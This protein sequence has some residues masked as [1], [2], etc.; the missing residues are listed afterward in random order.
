MSRW[1]QIALEAEEKTKPLPDTLQEPAKR[2]EGF[3]GEHLTDTLQKPAETVLPQ[4]VCARPDLLQV[5]AV[6]RADNP[7]ES[8]AAS[9]VPRKA[10]DMGHGLSPGGRPLTW[11]GKV[12]SLDEWRSLN[13]WER[14]GPDGKRWNALTQAWEASN[15]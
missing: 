13:E 3:E 6:C 12:V 10:T 7:N 15:D 11:T 8:A 5:P 1:L 9:S 4:A 14:H 2:S